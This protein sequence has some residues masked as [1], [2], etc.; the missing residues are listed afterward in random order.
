MRIGRRAFV[1]AS[2][3]ALVWPGIAGAQSGPPRFGLVVGNTA[4]NSGVGALNNADADAALIAAALRGCGFSVP[5][6]CVLINANRATLE[7]ALVAHAAR[8]RDAGPDAFGFFYYAGHGAAAANGRNYLIP[9]VTA[10]VMT[11]AIWPEC[12]DLPTVFSTLQPPTVSAAR[13]PNAHIVALDACRNTLRVP[14]AETAAPALSAA[15]DPGALTVENMRALPGASYRNRTSEAAQRNV[16]ISFS[17]WEGQLAS[18]GARNTANGPYA[19]ALALHMGA[20]GKAVFD[21]FEDVREE[22]YARTCNLQEPQNISS[23][24]GPSRAITLRRS[25]PP[26]SVLTEALGA[27]APIAVDSAAPALQFLAI[28]CQYGGALPA[29]SNPPRDVQRISRALRNSGYVGE[30]IVDAGRLQMI[31][32]VT[33]MSD[34]LLQTNGRGVGVL[35]FSGFG[36]SHDGENFLLPA[37]AAV[38]QPQDLYRYGVRVSDVLRELAR[39]RPRA[40]IVILD[41]GR[42]FSDD[43][44]PRREQPFFTETFNESSLLLAF[45]AQPGQLATETP[46][47]SAF[48]LALEAEILRPERRDITA[49]MLDL[50]HNVLER[51][52]G[53]QTPWFQTTVLEPIYFR[54]GAGLDNVQ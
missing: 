9:I 22:V 23:L 1:G 5:D 42:R 24:K 33:R 3:G 26:E 40:G 34:R 47:G 16:C 41:C 49:L 46:E 4:Y 20:A 18:D 36:A 11:D 29:L 43:V 45:S 39:G 51:T 32:E 44:S 53:R 21:M 35:Y 30:P 14:S 37:D 17:T 31:R 6:A 27:T 10:Q 54:D 50:N 2:A 8:V 13:P 12:L 28:G 7:A 48:A 38:Q 52:N 15:A 25:A 19:V